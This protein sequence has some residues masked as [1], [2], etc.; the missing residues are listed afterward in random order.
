MTSRILTADEAWTYLRRTSIGRIVTI[1]TDGVI[2]IFPVSYTTHNGEIL[3]PTQLGTKLRNI[4]T[5]PEALFEIDGHD[6]VAHMVWSVVVRAHG[7]IAATGSEQ[8]YADKVGLAP[9]ADIN[10]NQ[11]VTL[12]PQRIS[13]RAY[14]TR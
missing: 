13:G 8:K 9:L 3:I 4:A 11:I 14:S 2:D 12:V 1:S 7:R 5:H 6:Q 10:A